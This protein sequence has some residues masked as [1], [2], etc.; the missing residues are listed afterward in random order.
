M[1]RA[2]ST[3]TSVSSFWLTMASLAS[4]SAGCARTAHSVE[5]RPEDVAAVVRSYSAGHAVTVRQS[6]ESLTITSQHEPRVRLE[7]TEPP[8]REIDASLDDASM[9]DHDLVAFSKVSEGKSRE[10]WVPRIES[11]ELSFRGLHP[12]DEA[13]AFGVGFSAFGPSILFAPFIDLRPARWIGLE[14]GG[15]AA[16]GGH[17]GFAALRLAPLPL[18]PW[19][20]FTGAFIHGLAGYGEGAPEGKVTTT[21]GT[22]VRLGL[23]Y[24]F[25]AGHGAVRAELDAVRRLSRVWIDERR[26]AWGPYGGI[27]GC[28][29]F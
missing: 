28:Y 10:A 26:A 25:D 29:Y 4:S 1:A 15:W 24:E 11:A 16:P 5:L 3:L 13:L 27:S 9:A 22:G 8:G 21:S 7:L 2:V 12:R 20:P 17:W 18:G 14:L 19:R 6:G 23:E